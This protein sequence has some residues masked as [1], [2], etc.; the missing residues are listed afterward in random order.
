MRTLRL[1]ALLAA[2][3]AVGFGINAR[4]MADPQKLC[5]G[6]GSQCF[7]SACL[8]PYA[9]FSCTEWTKVDWS[10]CQPDSTANCT[11]QDVVCATY[12]PYVGGPCNNGKCPPDFPGTKTDYTISGCKLPPPPP[13]G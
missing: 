5:S 13:P 4:L 12:I 8:S 11:T 10:Y 1:L 3:F 7:N 6:V 9:G 2:C